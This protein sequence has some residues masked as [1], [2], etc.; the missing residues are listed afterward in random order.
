M[1]NEW[2]RRDVL[3]A[4]VLAGAGVAMTP[5]VAGCGA[6]GFGNTLDDITSAGRVRVGIAGEAP[7]SF[8]DD[9][10]QLSGA[11]G[12][13]HKEIFRRIGDIEVEPVEVSFEQLLDGLNKGNFDTVAAGMFILTDR[14]SRASFSEPVYCALG[15]LRGVGQPRGV[16]RLRVRGVRG[17][18]GRR[19]RVGGR[20]GVREGGGRRLR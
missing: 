14:C 15:A 8:V 18:R 10:G 7:Y 3:K 12:E 5:T 16:E 19:P 1:I 13:L 6:L 20:G 4:A 17:C 2:G 11:I 9:D